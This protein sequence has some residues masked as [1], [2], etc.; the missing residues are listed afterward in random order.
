M[1]TLS[2]VLQDRARE[3]VLV[4]KLDEKR[5]RC[6][7]CGHL[8]PI[9]EG[10]A[11]V[12][13]V[14]FNQGG[15][16]MVPFGYVAGA[17]CDPVEKKPFF[18]ARPGALAF[19]FGMLGCDLHCSYCQNWLT[20]QALRDPKAGSP[21]REVTAQQ[22]IRS[23]RSQGAE[24]V[25]STYNEPLIT[26][27]WAVAVFEEAK[28]AGLMTGFV[29]NGNGTQRVLE[30]LKPWTD[31][32]K[33]DLKGFD[34]RRYRRL[35]GRLQPVLDTIRMLYQ[36]GFWVEIVTLLVPGFNDS[37]AE[38]T[39][40]TE[41]IAGVSVDIPWH[42]TAFH[43]DYKMTE[44]D[45][46]QAKDLAR[47]AETGRRSGLRYVYA[48]NLPGRL[49]HLE[50]TYCPSC[51][52]LLVERRGFTVLSYSMTGEGRCPSCSTEIPGRWAPSFRPQI[53]DYPLLIRF[54][55]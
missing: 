28:K 17:Q 16:L 1:P 25:V 35:G 51:R 21:I 7:A 19:S 49:G 46:T 38:I 20:S 13:K 39:R 31:L 10:A 43:P 48:G 47:A 36:M 15:K 14:R 42:V 3:G 45:Y 40:L 53:S 18:H 26:S 24:I 5:I 44:P 11:G 37:D 41:F 29:S 32:Y 30:Y 6:L 54:H 22:L 2:E 50:N 52:Q 9:R 55:P 33:V 27:E 23:A 8:C 34:D 12:C 4:E